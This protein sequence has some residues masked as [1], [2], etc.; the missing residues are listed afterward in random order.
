M[1]LYPPL[2]GLFIVFGTYVLPNPLTVHNLRGDKM[3]GD[4]KRSESLA[5]EVTPVKILGSA[6]NIL[7]KNLLE[8]TDTVQ[9][10]MRIWRDNRAAGAPAAPAIAPETQGDRLTIS[11]EAL[12]AYKTG[13]KQLY[14]PAPVSVDAEIF[15]LTP[16]DRILIMVLEKA[17]GIRIRTEDDLAEAITGSGKSIAAKVQE[18]MEAAKKQ[19]EALKQAAT[20]PDRAGWGYLY[21]QDESEDEDQSFRINALVKTKDNREIP[22]TVDLR[23]PKDLAQSSTLVA[24]K[25]DA[26][27][28][29]PVV[30]HYNGFAADLRGTRFVLDLRA[31]ST[32]T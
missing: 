2:S 25:G 16:E 17:L 8:V 30:V 20:P 23:M 19:A 21:G 7:N 26:N 22:V 29:E 27:R 18:I 6:V 10:S 1:P 31:P 4:S 9:E 5:L 13:V 28:A 3:R 32:R 11:K 12:E 24:R 14:E 15:G